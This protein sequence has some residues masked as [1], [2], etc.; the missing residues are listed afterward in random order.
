M[1]KIF[2]IE[3]KIEPFNKKIK[4]DGDKSLSIRWSLLA[5]LAEGKSIAHNLPRSEDVMSALKCLKKIGIKVSLKK[6]NMYN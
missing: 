5:S 1:R 2:K 3:K 4:V 6:K